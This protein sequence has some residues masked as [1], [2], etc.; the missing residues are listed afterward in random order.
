MLFFTL[1]IFSQSGAIY[2]YSVGYDSTKAFEQLYFFAYID[3]INLA[4]FIYQ[5]FYYIF[6]AYINKINLARFINLFK[7]IKIAR[8][9]VCCNLWLFCGLSHSKE[10][11]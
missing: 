5:L 11:Q 10:C 9:A 1:L 8:G 6:F 3:R 2:D 4:R 7:D